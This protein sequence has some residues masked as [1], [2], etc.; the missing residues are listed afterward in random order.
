MLAVW[1]SSPSSQMGL[2]WF[3]F[4]LASVKSTN[5]HQTVQLPTM[6]ESAPRKNNLRTKSGLCFQATPPEKDGLS[7]QVQQ[8]PPPFLVASFNFWVKSLPGK[9]KS[10]PGHQPLVVSKKHMVV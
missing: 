5:H 1:S 10:E 7:D 2:A 9:K 6:E 3:K 8:L 4:S